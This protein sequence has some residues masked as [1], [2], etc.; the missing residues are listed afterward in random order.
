MRFRILLLASAAIALVLLVGCSDNKALNPFQ[1][2]IINNADNFAFQATGIKSVSTTLQHN[3]SNSGDSAKV[4]QASAITH[5]TA[6]VTLYDDAGAQ[7]YSGSLS[8]NGDFFSGMGTPGTW[9]VKVV[10]TG[11]S[12]TL[13]FRAQKQ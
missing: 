6:T 5:G 2:E 1:P 12:G 3:W 13:N 7:V 11:L 9:K 8:N 4:N 10:L